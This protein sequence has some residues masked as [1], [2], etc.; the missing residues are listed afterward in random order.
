MENIIEMTN[1]YLLATG[2]SA[3]PIDFSCLYTLLTEQGFKILSYR[4]GH[5]LLKKLQLQKY[6]QDHKAFTIILGDIRVV[7]YRDSISTA[8]KLFCLAHELGHIVL[9]HTPEGIL[10]KS[11][12]DECDSAQEREADNFAYAFLAPAAVIKKCCFSAFEI[13]RATLLNEYHAN[14]ILISIQNYNYGDSDKL[15]AENFNSYIESHCRLRKRHPYL[16]RYLFRIH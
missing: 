5:N 15:V 2:I 16:I 13:C 1:K 3:L 9:G 8:E 4:Q 7:M 6:S 11:N 10:G 12:S 14:Q